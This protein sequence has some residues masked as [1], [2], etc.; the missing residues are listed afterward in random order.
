MGVRHPPKVIEKVG[1]IRY[2]KHP[3]RWIKNLQAEICHTCY[4]RTLQQRLIQADLAKSRFLNVD[5]YCL[6]SFAADCL[7]AFFRIVLH[8]RK[9]WTN[10]LAVATRHICISTTLP[11]Y[12]RSG[13]ILFFVWR[14]LNATAFHEILDVFSPVNR[15]LLNAPMGKNLVRFTEC[16][17]LCHSLCTI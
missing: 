12:T 1:E 13:C 9:S 10:S 3:N 7:P 5:V 11:Y 8:K 2:G 16:K 14:R 17:L 6:S 15:S 4:I